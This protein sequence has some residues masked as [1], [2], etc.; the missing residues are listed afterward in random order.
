M[1]R[2]VVRRRVDGIQLSVLPAALPSLQMQTQ[3][4]GQVK[5]T[6]D[7]EAGSFF[8]FLFSSRQ[9]FSV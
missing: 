2:P 8:V 1:D 7:G 5:V 3:G 6:Q 9:G 4:S